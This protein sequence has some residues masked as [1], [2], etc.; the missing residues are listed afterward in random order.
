MRVTNVEDTAEKI[1]P[2]KYESVFRDNLMIDWSKKRLTTQERLNLDVEYQKSRLSHSHKMK[3]QDAKALHVDKVMC[4]NEGEIYV[5]VLD[6][7]HELEL[8]Q[9][10][11]AY[12]NY[13]YRNK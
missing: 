13:V 4:R 1:I 8:S 2:E 3:V 10:A 6:N 11:W 12:K 9:W 7:G 5:A